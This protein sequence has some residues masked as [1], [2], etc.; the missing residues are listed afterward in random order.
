MDMVSPSDQEVTG[1]ISTVGEFFRSPT[2]TS[3][4]GSRPRKELESVSISLRL[5]MQSS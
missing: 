2:K 1:S 5:S 3:S 4:T